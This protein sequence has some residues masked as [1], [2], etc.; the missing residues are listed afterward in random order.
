MRHLTYK[1]TDAERLSDKAKVIE[2]RSDDG[3]ENPPSGSCEPVLSL[4]L[5]A[6]APAT[7]VYQL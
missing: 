5:H 7:L 1:E 2:C 4:L 6:D 3:K